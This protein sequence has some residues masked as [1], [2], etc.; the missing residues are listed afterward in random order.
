MN[1]I[2]YD[3]EQIFSILDFLEFDGEDYIY[4]GEDPILEEQ[5]QSIRDIWKG[6]VAGV[7]IYQSENEKLKTSI[8][9]IRG[10]S[11]KRG[12]Y[13]CSGYTKL[14]RRIEDKCNNILGD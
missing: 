4:Y 13:S 1:K 5:A 9:C 14:L 7:K 11:R 6:Y 2:K 10:V 3:F 8:S 12:Y